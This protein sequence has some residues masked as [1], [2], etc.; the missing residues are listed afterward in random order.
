MPKCQNCGFDPDAPVVRPLTN[1]MNEYFTA[2]GKSF[3][4]LND[5]ATSVKI[6]PKTGEPFTVYLKSAI[7][8]PKAPEAPKAPATPPAK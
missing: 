6:T 2:D 8:A 1:K 7:P 4:I 3:G 5:D